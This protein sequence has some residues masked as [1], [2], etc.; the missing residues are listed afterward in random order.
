M[1]ITI[2]GPTSSGKSSTARLLAQKL[3]FYH[4]NSGLLYRALAYLVKYHAGLDE[5]SMAQLE[6]NVVDAYLDS[7]RLHY[8]VSS[9]GTEIY[10]DGTTITPLLRGNDIGQAASIVSGNEYV[11]KTIL[12]RLHSIANQHNC[13]VDGRDVG[14]C[15]FPEAEVK[16][17]LTAS[18]HKRAERWLGEQ[19][20]LGNIFSFA[21]AQ[22][23]IIK[24]D[25]RDKG[26]SCA[27]LVIPK[28]A[29]LIDNSD[30]DLAQTVEM[31][32]K[33]VEKKRS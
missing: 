25:T 22:H 26:R 11:R 6:P 31:M 19:K 17:Y 1:I 21:D 33:E 27:P 4:I 5:T 9:E 10:F 29:I 18:L 12:T 8:R 20:K 32:M 3:N 23:E 24:R 16:F 28:D 14:S 15:V 13:V 7:H 2:D 30:L